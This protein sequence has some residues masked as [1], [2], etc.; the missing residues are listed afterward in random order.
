MPTMENL[1]EK[2]N[3]YAA[4]MRRHLETVRWAC[5]YWSRGD[6]EVA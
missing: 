1:E 2:Y 5:A 4:M 6:D 3:C